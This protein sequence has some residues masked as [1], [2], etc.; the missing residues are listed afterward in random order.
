MKKIFYLLIVTAFTCSYTTYAQK[1]KLLEGKLDVL[2]SEEKLNLEY[3]YSD[4]GV[5]KFAKEE[6]YI[7]KKKEDYNKKEPGRGEQWENSWKADR[8]NRFQPQFEELFSKHSGLAAGDIPTA[9]Y[10]LIFKTKFTEPGYNVYVSRMNA[11][12]DGEALL[13]E[14]ADHSKVIARMSVLNCPGRT[15]G[16]NDYDTGLRIQ[17]AYAVAGKGLGKFFKDKL[18]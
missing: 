2:Q 13:V 17:E 14:T 11:E 4:M 16:G 12:I 6:E 5:G 18:K 15:F 8:K 3:D 10:T 7:A 1:V 9:R